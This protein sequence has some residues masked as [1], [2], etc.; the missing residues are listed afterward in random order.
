MLGPG[1]GEKELLVHS[2]VPPKVINRRHGTIAHHL[3]CPSPKGELNNK[4]ADF[5]QTFAKKKQ[6]WEEP[7]HLH[8]RDL[9]QVSL[10]NI[11]SFTWTVGIRSEPLSQ[12]PWGGQ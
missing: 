11:S 4:K 6:A 7:C 3:G 10:S 9:R 1:N 2:P 8:W 5:R 12:R